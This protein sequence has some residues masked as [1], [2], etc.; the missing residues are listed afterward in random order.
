LN[1]S[2]IAI[3]NLKTKQISLIM[4]DKVIQTKIKGYV[5]GISNNYLF[6]S[7]L[8]EDE[9]DQGQMSIFTL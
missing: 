7:V 6:F 8:K 5:C 9:T 3:T 1:G 4:N 2:I